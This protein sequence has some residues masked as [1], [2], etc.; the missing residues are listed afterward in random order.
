MHVGNDP[1]K[2][3][4]NPIEE[5]QCVN[6][7]VIFFSHKLQVAYKPTRGFHY[8]YSKFHVNSSYYN[9]YSKSFAGVSEGV[10]GPFPNHV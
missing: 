5:H 10:G 8:I 2:K 9:P 7:E 1:L 4:G 6:L 3:Y